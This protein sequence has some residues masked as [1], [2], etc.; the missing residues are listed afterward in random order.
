MTGITV[1]SFDVGVKNL[2]FCVL[3][4]EPEAEPGARYPIVAWRCMDLT[5]D[6]GASEAICSAKKRD[7]SECTNAAKVRVGDAWLCG[8][9]NPDKGGTSRQPAKKKTKVAKL[10]YDRLANAMLDRLMALDELW[11]QCDH[12]V[13]E[14]QFKK[15]RRMIF[16]SAMLFG[17]FIGA[18]QRDP[19][20]RISQVKFASSRNKLQLYDGPAITERTRKNDKEH[21]KWLAVKH[22]EHMIRG[23][24]ENL[25]FLK[26]YPNKK[27]DL[28]DAFLQGADY[29]HN[30]CRAVKRPKP[31][32]R[33]RKTTRPRPAKRARKT[34]RKK[35]AQPADHAT[36]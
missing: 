34:T 31:A 28:C 16:L 2:A 29:L 4:Y 8:V 21:R 5:D 15:N 32:K 3:H 14:Q 17:Y 1:A 20:R 30:G 18:H 27:D 24:S 25:A 26:R 13:I 33:A 35:T 22:C 9:H 36:E 12:V 11:R 19:T 7:G 23:D 6:T 10:S